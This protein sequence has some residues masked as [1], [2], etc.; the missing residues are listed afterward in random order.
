M[1]RVEHSSVKMD[2]QTPDHILDLVRATLGGPIRLDPCTVESNPTDALAIYTEAD[3]GLAHPWVGGFF[4]NPPYGRTLLK[5]SEHIAKQKV[6][7]LVL[8]PARTDT[9]WFHNLWEWSDACCFIKGRLRFKGAK[10]GAPF[11]SA[12]LYRADHETTSF[13][14][15]FGPLGIVI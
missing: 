5:W 3:D 13:A 8:A 2:W 15:H 14:A 4:C 10:Q 9:R 11:P 12:V 6:E 7:G 1:T